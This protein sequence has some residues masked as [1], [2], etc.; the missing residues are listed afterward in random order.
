MVNLNC[1]IALQL[2][3]LLL[4]LDEWTKQLWDMYQWNA[5]WLVKNKKVLLFMTVWVDQETTTLSE[6]SQAEEDKYHMIS[7]M[8]GIY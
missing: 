1:L 2:T 5:T 7:L 6:I 8:R 3:E 4:R